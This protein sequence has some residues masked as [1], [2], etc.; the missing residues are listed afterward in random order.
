M[1]ILHIMASKA[2]GGAET[3]STDM[4]ESLHAAGVAELCV[5]AR[6]STNAPRLAAAGVPLAC[7]VLDAPF[8][9]WRRRRLQRL[10]EDFKPDLV[11]CWMR[12]AASLVPRLDVP[13]IGWF[14]GY[15]DPSHFAR[16]SHFV[17]VTP[18][19]VDHMVEKGVARARAHYVQTFPTIED[20]PAI[21]RARHATPAD[22]TLLL[23][24]SRLHEKKG[25]DVFLKAL[26]RL[27]SC[28]AWIAGDGPL[29]GELKALAETLGVSERV[30][31][32]GWRTE[33]G[34]LLKTADICV[35]PSR[36]EPFG[37]VMIE[38]WAAG[39]PLVAAASQGPSALIKDGNNG[40]LVPVDDVDALAG[41]IRRLIETPALRDHLVRQGSEDYRR[42]FTR[43]TVTQRMCEVYKQLIAEAAGRGQ[44]QKSKELT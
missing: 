38:A 37:T 44:E 1:R 39:T 2:N 43:Q 11:H 25:L 5:I 6:D 29:E 14:G 18:G 12:R 26:Q 41:A 28:I 40:L 27:P 3:Y 21:D 13:V 22:A 4:M 31:F 42:N 19:I 24:L 9:F 23:T 36:W 15:Y 33:R 35:L 17:G 34:A 30:R 7:E 20:A 16:C 10:V 32:L 8:D